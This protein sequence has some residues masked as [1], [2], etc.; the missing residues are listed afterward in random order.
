MILT[1]IA[2]SKGNLARRRLTV[3]QSVCACFGRDLN[4]S[5]SDIPDLFLIRTKIKD[6]RII[7]KISMIEK[8]GTPIFSSYV[9]LIYIIITYKSSYLRR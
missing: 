6:D 2:A 7:I 3:N 1:P 8:F 5:V 9:V 4:E